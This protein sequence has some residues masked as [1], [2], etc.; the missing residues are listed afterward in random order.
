MINLIPLGKRSVLKVMKH[1]LLPPL[2]FSIDGD[3]NEMAGAET[4]M[5]THEVSLKLENIHSGTIK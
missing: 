4:V 3:A 2:S 5:L 1:V